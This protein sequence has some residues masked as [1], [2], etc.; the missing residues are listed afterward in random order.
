[1]K[2]ELIIEDDG[3]DIN[4]LPYAVDIPAEFGYEWAAIEY[5]ETKEEAIKFAQEKFGADESG[6][7]CLVSG[8]HLS[9]TNTY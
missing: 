3:L 7:V 8:P 1:M 5:F 2:K 9:K 6:N 4:Y